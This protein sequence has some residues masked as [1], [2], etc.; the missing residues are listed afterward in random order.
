MQ[1]EPLAEPG[2]PGWL[3]V[4]IHGVPRPREWDAVLTVEAEVDGDRAVF[5][6]LPEGRS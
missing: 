2:P 4:G 6:A 5:V 3:D 1:L